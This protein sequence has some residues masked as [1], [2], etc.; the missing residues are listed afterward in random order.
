M[1]INKYHNYHVYIFKA[2]K[3]GKKENVTIWYQ[4]ALRI[5]IMLRIYY[6]FLYNLSRGG[7]I[8]I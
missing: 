4:L 6:Y 1:F 2:I 8:K 5:T 7:E 3:K